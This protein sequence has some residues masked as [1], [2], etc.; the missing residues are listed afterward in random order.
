MRPARGK[1]NVASADAH[2]SGQQPL[3]PDVE[4]SSPDASGHSPETLEQLVTNKLER[5][6]E[7]LRALGIA[8]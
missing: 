5:L 2:T 8:F 1:T 4:S 7:E 3:G 6:A